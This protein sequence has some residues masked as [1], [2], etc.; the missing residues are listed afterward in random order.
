MDED[1]LALMIKRFKFS[2]ISSPLKKPNNCFNCGKDGH[3][4]KDCPYLKQERRSQDSSSE[5]EDDEKSKPKF[6]K[7][8]FYCKDDEK[9]K[10]NGKEKF[11]KRPSRKAFV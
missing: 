10:G 9:K 2:R 4:Y 5:E 1:D 8:K 6:K 11:K 3:F 7:K